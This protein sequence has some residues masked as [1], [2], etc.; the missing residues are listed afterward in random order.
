MI[1][2]RFFLLILLIVVLSGCAGTPSALKISAAERNH[3]ALEARL[4]RKSFQQ[5]NFSAAEKHL[6]PLSQ[7]PSVNQPLYQLELASS[8]LLLGQKEEAHHALLAAHHSIEG[9][10]DTGL[11]KQA[12]SLWG[13]EADKVFKGEPYERGTLYFLLALSFLEQNNPDNA[14]AALKTGLLAD[15]DTQ[16]NQYKSDF[17]L[18]QF[19][20]AKCYDLRGEPE[21]RDQMLKATFLSITSRTD[22]SHQYI[23]QLTAAYTDQSQPLPISLA[24]ICALASAET[25]EDW[26]RNNDVPAA[27]AIEMSQWAHTAT[28]DLN[29]LNFNTLAVIWRGTAPQAIRAGQYGETRLIKSGEIEPNLSYSLHID[30]V[31]KASYP[32]LGD[33]NYQA[34]TRG[35]RTMDN[36]LDNQ[37]SIKTAT[38]VGGDTLIVAGAAGTGDSG[39]DAVLVLGGVLMKVISAAANPEADIRFWH[40]LPAKF[41]LIPLSLPPGTHTVQLTIQQEGQAENQQESLEWE[42]P[43]HTSLSTLHL[44]VRPPLSDN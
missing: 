43:P 8:Y 22:Q 9:F 1:R 3:M 40:N 23:Q 12:A 6:L 21:L 41:D 13:E 16:E 18:L 5:G 15:S 17:G 19:L 14:L 44:Q 42:I 2:D 30:N 29:L 34:T 37:A 24:T 26:L 11:E 31:Q 28:A 7:R 38:N 32:N 4:A 33:I 20:A 27:K 35:G 25:I 39:R 36:V 10:F